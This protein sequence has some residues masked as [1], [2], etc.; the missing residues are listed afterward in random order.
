MKHSVHRILIY[1]KL[2]FCYAKL[3]LIKNLNYRINFL[4]GL[5]INLAGSLVL[6]YFYDVVFDRL[7][8]IGTWDK[9][10]AMLLAGTYMIVESLYIGLAFHSISRFPKI[11]LDGD[12]DD[13][14]ILP[15][16]PRAALA[17]Q[18]MDYGNILNALF[19]IGLVYYFFPTSSISFSSLANYFIAILFGLIFLS[20]L[21]LL[22][23]SFAFWF[24]RVD[25]LRDALAWIMDLGARP[26][27]I[28]PSILRN[29]F[30]W[31]LPFFLIANVPV[32]FLTGERNW[33]NIFL[34]FFAIVPFYIGNKIVWHLGLR[35][36]ESASY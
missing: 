11:I 6:F 20:N 29:I 18:E 12:L 5:I 23:M 33:L 25:E 7:G 14:L 8:A 9:T 10:H 27:F 15:I 3:N 21:L 22:L 26:A 30:Y 36:Y 35:K 4:I 2:Y 1:L 17:L 34:F 31:I 32:E 13:Y 24:G 19:G 28:Y 16:S